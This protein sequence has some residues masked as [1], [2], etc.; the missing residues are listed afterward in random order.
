MHT[1][2]VLNW[3]TSVFEF[4]GKLPE[5]Q[6]LAGQFITLIVFLLIP[7]ALFMALVA[8][9]WSKPFRVFVFGASILGGWVGGMV[10]GSILY[11]LWQVGSHF[12][13]WPEASENALYVV[14]NICCVGGI[15]CLLYT[16]YRDIPEL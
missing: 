1:L 14:Q 10:S 5:A 2:V 8:N 12:F 7:I 13:L 6:R 9:L 15:G 4:L 11:M 16:A 3:L